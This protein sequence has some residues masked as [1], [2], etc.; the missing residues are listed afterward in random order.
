MRPEQK[1]II[2]LLALIISGICF[3]I[4]FYHTGKGFAEAGILGSENG[5]FLLASVIIGMMTL[6]YMVALFWKGGEKLG[7]S[8]YVVFALISFLA[9]LNYFYPTYMSR[10]LLKDELTIKKD[11]LDRIA[12]RSNEVLYSQEG[13]VLKEQVD[14]KRDEL[15]N[16]IEDGG[17]KDRSEEDLKQIERILGLP[18]GTGI[19]HLKGYKKTY[20]ELAIIYDSL[21][22]KALFTK[23]VT[24]SYPQ[25]QSIMV[26][27]E[28][29]KDL[30]GN[31]A[32][33]TITVLENAPLILTDEQRKNAK[34]IIR[35]IVNAYK[36]AG[37]KTQNVVKTFPFQDN[38]K[39]DNEELGRFNH[40][41]SSAFD[42]LDNF[43][44]W[45]LIFICLLIDFIVPLGLYF[46]VR[47][48]DDENNQ[49]STG[50][51]IFS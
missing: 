30:L 47:K 46:M 1:K 42:Y 28:Q 26:E 11:S 48:G 8:F 31:K 2:K 39:V 14:K 35:E 37:K 20:Q 50:K 9:N 13:H 22:N 5:A 45:I 23:L 21:V 40:T 7:L 19:T 36:D 18:E 44:T 29:K 32:Q 33:K 4:G 15:H 38:I 51:N 41:I 49:V 25:N 34:A 24:M 12:F 16:Q 3:L 43:G 10:T 27:I 17:F 6:S